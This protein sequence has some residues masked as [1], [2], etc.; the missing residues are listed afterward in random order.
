M[1]AQLRQNP[2]LECPDYALS[3]QLLFL[4]QRINLTDLPIFERAAHARI[5]GIHAQVSQTTTV[6]KSPSNA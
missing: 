3:A 6:V 4:L 1:E 5:A 2:C